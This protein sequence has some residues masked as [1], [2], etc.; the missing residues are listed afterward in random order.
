MRP[1]IKQ[2]AF[3]L[4]KVLAICLVA[5]LLWVDLILMQT[6]LPRILF[7][8][9]AFVLSVLLVVLGAAAISLHY[10][11]KLPMLFAVLSLMYSLVFLSVVPYAV[12]F[13][14]LLML[15]AAIHF[16][17]N[18][19]FTEPLLVLLP[20]TAGA[21]VFLSMVYLPFLNGWV[22]YATNRM[23]YLGSGI[24]AI[25][26]LNVQ[27]LQALIAVP[28]L[29]MFFIAKKGYIKIFIWAGSLRPNPSVKRDGAK[30]RRPLP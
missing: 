4:G 6:A 22:Y 27:S 5:P 30:A 1:A 2:A 20:I 3:F 17:H 11:S 13:V 7:V 9:R 23:S 14:G 10:R 29:F 15:V 21:W 25:G 24:E 12:A 19:R 8:E 18:N 28:L 16:I 26:S